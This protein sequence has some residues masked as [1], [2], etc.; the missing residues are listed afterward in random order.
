MNI[1][2]AWQSIYNNFDI[3]YHATLNKNTSQVKDV[4][5]LS[6]VYVKTAETLYYATT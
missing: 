4:F 6:A 3:N 1:L 5:F 2:L